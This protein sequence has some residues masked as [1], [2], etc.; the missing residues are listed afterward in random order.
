MHN[1]LRNVMFSILQ[2][3]TEVCEFCENILGDVR[4]FLTDNQ[5]E[6]RRHEFLGRVESS[7]I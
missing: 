3:D 7:M 4:K 5:T 1:D 6:V 2:D